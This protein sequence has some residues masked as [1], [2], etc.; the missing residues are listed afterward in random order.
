MSD[1]PIRI[2]AADDHTLLRSALC[3]MLA[4]ESDLAIVGQAV[5]GPSTVRLASDIQ[6]DVILLDLEMP[7]PGPLAT[8]RQIRALA[9]GARVVVLTMHDDNDLIQSLLAEGAFGYLHKSASRE[10]LLSAI[11]STVAGGT[12]VFT[13][14]RPATRAD[15][16]VSPEPPI[17]LT[18][19]EREVLECVAEALSNRQIGR[20]LGITEGTVKRHLRNIFAKLE[21]STRLDAVNKALAARVIGR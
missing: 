13:S 1:A 9:P 3:T 4:K 5:D 21:A 7:G 8:L 16:R 15:V 17:S 20:R 14:Q 2:L 19:R 11:H 12:T 10:M 18:S 6:P